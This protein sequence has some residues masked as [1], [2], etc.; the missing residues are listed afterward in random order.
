MKDVSIIIVNYGT[1]GLVADCVSSILEKTEGVTYEI[2]IVDNASPDNSFAVL[3]EKYSTAENITCLALKENVGFGRANNAGFEC[4]SGRYIF[5]LNPDTRLKNDAIVILSEY[6]DHHP[7]AGACCGNLL[8]VDNQPATSFRRLY[9]SIALEF[10]F[11]TNYLIEKVLYRGNYKYNH[12]GHVI[13][14]ASISGAD[15]MIR[16]T[17]IEEIG[18]F[19][20]AFFMYYEDTDLCYRIHKSH[21]ALRN[22]PEALIY[23][24]E[25][26]STSRL[27]RKATLNFNGRSIFYTKHH[28]KLY[29]FTANCIWGTAVLVKALTLLFNKDSNREYWTTSLKLLT[30]YY[31]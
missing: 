24:F 22:V 15:L 28:S 7:E 6:L 25:G 30:K 26:K 4:T 2:V 11:M 19:D 23:H 29:Q 18:F 3:E 13:D 14:V 1:E 8:Q 20:P 17:L 16:R 12:T 27:D 21:Y 31:L 9:P 5:C 10:S